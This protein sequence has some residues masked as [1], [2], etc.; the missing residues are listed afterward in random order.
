MKARR[1]REAGQQI[2]PDDENDPEALI[3]ET[4]LALIHNKYFF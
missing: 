2:Y 1:L 3:V 4:C